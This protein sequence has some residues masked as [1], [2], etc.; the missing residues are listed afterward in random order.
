MLVGALSDQSEEVRELA[1]TGLGEIG[2]SRT[3]TTLERAADK[4]ENPDVRAAAARAIAQ[5]RSQEQNLTA[6][7]TQPKATR[8]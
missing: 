3:I 1:A 4:D 2:D 6:K 7:P 8:P 5:I